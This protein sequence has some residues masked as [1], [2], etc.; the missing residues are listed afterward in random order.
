MATKI[1]IPKPEYRMDPLAEATA[2]EVQLSALSMFGEVLAGTAYVDQRIL[3]SGGLRPFSDFPEAAEEDT[4]ELPDPRD[5]ILAREANAPRML[6]ALGVMLVD[7]LSERDAALIG[8]RAMIIDNFEVG[9]SNPAD[10]APSDPLPSEIPWH[11]ETLLRNVPS[12]MPTGQGVRIG[13]LD[14]GIDAAHSEFAGKHISYMQF[15]RG[16]FQVST[17]PKDFG[18]H[19]THVAGIAAGKTCGIAPEADLAV[20]AVLTKRARTGNRGTFS[21]ILAGYNWL[22]HS[23]HAPA[24]SPI[25]TC[26]IINLSLGGRGYNDYLYSSIAT[27]LTITRSLLIAAIGNSGQLGRDHHASP[28]NYDNVLG[29]GATD[30]AD[31]V[32]DFSDWGFEANNS[33]HKPDMSAPGVAIQSA[34]PGNGYARKSGTSMAA[35]L[36]AGA[37]A[38]IIQKYPRLARNPQRLMI[39]LLRAV[40]VSSVNA[41]ANVDHKGN[42]RLGTGRLDLSRI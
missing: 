33:V 3:S 22:A 41:S 37:A 1:I 36:V 17:D 28:G 4:F 19:G 34:V 24:G 38:L 8:E 5:I 21:Q 6:E 42:S 40:D 35:P 11:L 39:E 13:I 2:A 31:A 14:T 29:I 30:R 10:T 23:N 18:D 7:D 20:A 16:G 27:L 32:A 12:P 25:S 26:P 15:D 9:L